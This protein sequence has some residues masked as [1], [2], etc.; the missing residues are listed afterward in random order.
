[1]IRVVPIRV[2]VAGAESWVAERLRSV[3][4]TEAGVWTPGV[5]HRVAFDPQ[6]GQYNSTILLRELLDVLPSRETKVVGITSL[7]LFIPV[8]T[9]VFGEA[10]LD[11]HVAIA[12][13]HRL[14]N[15]F[16]G[17]PPDPGAV[18]QR[19]EKEVVHELGHTF[20][21]THC[22]DYRCVMHAS[23]FVEDIDLKGADFCRACR[24]T[25]E[26]GREGPA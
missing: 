13:T 15:E 5:D 18:L 21:L 22:A 26:G 1:M 6:R 19:L 17:L 23:T 20:N 16:Y 8:L 2:T 10:Q 24:R 12:S 3:F 14:R 11:G 25:L 9:Y 7:D 4:G